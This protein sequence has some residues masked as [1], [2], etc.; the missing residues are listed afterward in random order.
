LGRRALIARTEVASRAYLITI[1]VWGAK[2]RAILVLS[3]LALIHP[4]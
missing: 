4:P 2:A 3:L 1:S